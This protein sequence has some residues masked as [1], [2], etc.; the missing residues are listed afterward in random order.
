MTVIQNAPV[1]SRREAE[2][3]RRRNLARWTGL[4]ALIGAGL[5]LGMGLAFVFATP[6]VGLDTA[7]EAAAPIY[8]A[9]EAAFA[10]AIAG[11]ALAAIAG[12]PKHRFRAGATS[13]RGD[14]A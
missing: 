7:R 9:V 6:A 14:N 4:G 2:R 5:G 8:L 10:G 12:L 1:E 3:V 11:G 13:A